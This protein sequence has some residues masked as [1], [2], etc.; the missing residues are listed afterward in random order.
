MTSE[1]LKQ[2]Q[3]TK[4]L[5]QKAR[6][7][8]KNRKI[9]EERLAEAEKEIA[10][11]KKMGLDTRALVQ[12]HADGQ[13]TF[14]KREYVSAAAMAEKTVTAAVKVQE[15]IV[16][17]VL[18]AAHGVVAMIDDQGQDHQAIE[19]LLERSRQ[20]LKEGRREDAML[21]ALDSKTAAEQYAD[22]RMSEMFVQLGHLIELGEKEKI[23]V[24]ARKQA[25]TKAK[26][27][28]EE[29]DREGSLAK[30]VACFKGLQEAFSKL[31]EA[32]A[33]S[34]MEMVEG[35]SQGVDMSAITSLVEKSR[36]AMAKG[37]IEESLRLLDEAQA[38][39]RPVLAKAVEALVAAQQQRVEWLVAHG[40]S[41]PRLALS[42]KKVT[43]VN[44]TGDSEEAL[45][46]LR[47][48]EKAVRD[49]EMEVVLERI[50][51]LRPRMVLAKQTK[52]NLDR[53]ISRL[54]EAR[55]ATV[56]GR[57][58]EAMDTLDEASAEL[59]DILAPFRRVEGELDATR[60]A[61]LQARRMRIVS[62]EASRLVAK[63]REDALAGRLGDS[64]D[65]L[66]KARAVLTRIIQER[67]AR[68]VFNGH[69]MVAAGISIG[70]D[71]G[72]R[73]D[74]LDDLVDD[75][76][77]GILDGISTRLATLNLELETALIAATWA[78]FRR[79]AEALDSVPPGTDLT[80]ALD[81]RR[82]A[83]ELLE[84]K[85]WYGSRSLAEGVLEEV[86]KARTVTMEAR[87]AQARALLGI[88][89]SLGIES[90]T[91]LERMAMVEADRG[92]GTP[93]LEK[94][95]EVIMFAKSLARD[96]VSRSLAQ[97]VRS[98]AAARKKGV[99]TAHV[100]RLTEEASR[101]MMGDDLERGY[102]AYEGAK[103]ELEKTSALHSEVYDLIVLLSRLSGELH[104]PLD[105]RIAQQLS[106]TKRL[107]E[108]GL[109]DG[110]R[111]SARACYKEAESIGAIVLAPRVLQ[112]A[113][114]MLPVMRQLD[115]DVAPIEAA[116]ASADE[117]LK[118]GEA[119][120]AL[121]AA[122]EERRKMAEAAAESIRTEIEGVRLMLQASGTRPGEGAV[123]DL[124]NKAESLLDDQR[125]A[126]ALQAARFAR[127]E[128]VQYLNARASAGRELAA[129]DAGISDIETLGVDVSDAR[130]ILDQ[131][132]KHR[133]GGR[134]N[135]VAEIARN[136]LQ[137]ARTKAEESIRSDIN[138]IER[139]FKAQDMRGRDLEGPPRAARGSILEDVRSC[140]YASAYQGLQIYSESLSELSEVRNQ[141]ITSLSKLAEVMVRMPLSPCKAEAEGL[142]SRAQQAFDSGS[143]HEALALS[144]ECRAAGS[145]ALKRHEMAAARLEEART[146]ALV[147]GGRK[148]IVPEVA[149]LLDSAAKALANGRYESMDTFLLRAARLHALES[150]RAGGRA[151]AEL[152]NMA[153]MLPRAGL[154]VDDLPQEAKEL[155]DR[156]MTD[157]LGE[158]NLRE[159]TGDVRSNVRTAVEERIAAVREQVERGPGETGAARSLLSSAERSLSEGQLEKA[160]YQ[161]MDAE[162]AIGATIT[163]VL[164][165]KDLT[166]RYLEQAS[167]ANGLGTGSAGLDSY[168]KALASGK[169]T[170]SLAHL[171]K[172][173]AAEEASNASYLP[174]LVLRATRVVNKGEAPA[175][176][177]TVNGLRGKEAIIAPVLW[178]QTSV[179][180]PGPVAETA[181]ITVIYR[182]LFVA[183]P[184][185]KELKREGIA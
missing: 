58:R 51:T 182:A 169:V 38:A 143:F 74:E 137:G 118:E 49:S 92:T 135:L 105:S 168:R 110:A 90:E 7:A 11:A 172:A 13:A 87:K 95:D 82:K 142:M 116:L 67:C 125:H 119:A 117:S 134:C 37:R 94:V 157:L 136:A 39:I 185:V 26:K 153:A 52:L 133:L 93:S 128:A 23:A 184:F 55:T 122:K 131:A 107:F 104:L 45:E 73:P 69:L 111:T 72:D 35:G 24:A 36:E 148:A 76:R 132:R 152:V 123:M 101:A 70:A 63:A 171:R 121:A 61:F 18:A 84:K 164:E 91:L 115:A 141:C 166:R 59:D 1:Y 129:A 3:L 156:K 62:S 146:N 19:S 46:L 130:E 71:M 44:A 109:Y 147:N 16:E 145:S 97:V 183:K 64:Y 106:E 120:A 40:V 179:K 113:R 17:E 83:Q 48:S 79:A 99:S 21:A 144:E 30:A 20:L 50:E 14:G 5:E 149:D 158:R 124:V 68:Q 89:S 161:A 139:G 25:L 75:L 80:A 78:E 27:L 180:L 174:D 57:A 181:R 65:T 150:S 6:E 29:G 9:A 162:T 66:A 112:E 77:E 2:L 15:E 96:E 47:R 167:L 12:S 53:V 85:D 42:I 138:R 175:I 98:S 88:C 177:V 86:E 155:L 126:D 10:L 41:A 170:G 102:T 8:A 178:P 28:H 81:M 103:R 176:A 173:V 56:Y 54:E 140:N 22:R 159:T 114:D 31:A 33:G 32:R 165:L 154:T 43:E 4:Q 163:D 34:I 160:L 151:V 100:D 127:S 108:A 60:K